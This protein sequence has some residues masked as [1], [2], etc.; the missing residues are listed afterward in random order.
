V[1][2]PRWISLNVVL[3][4]HLAQLAEHGGLDGV[5][6]RGLLE[7]A[8]ARPLQHAAYERCDLADLAA[9]YALGLLRNHPFLDGNKRTALV[10]METFLAINGIALG[11]GDTEC[12]LTIEAAAAG[13]IDDH[14]LAAWIRTYMRPIPAVGGN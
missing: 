14:A 6:D 4:T 13:E 9:T 2:E 1:T 11:A 5:R 7:S 8:L 3:A 12:V 10:T